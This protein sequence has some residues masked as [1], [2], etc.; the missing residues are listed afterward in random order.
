MFFPNSGTTG[1]PFR[2]HVPSGSLST[3]GASRQTYSDQIAIRGLALFQR[4]RW[5][6]EI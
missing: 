3:P 6:T 5:S 1:V 4:L 2:V